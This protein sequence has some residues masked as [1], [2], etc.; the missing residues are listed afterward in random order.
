MFMQNL[1][2]IKGVSNMV[3]KV[4]INKDIIATFKPLETIR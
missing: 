3:T 2:Y 4:L 1:P